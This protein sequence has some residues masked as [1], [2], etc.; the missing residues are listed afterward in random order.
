MV[1]ETNMVNM[2]YGDG[3]HHKTWAILI[4]NYVLTVLVV[5]LRYVIMSFMHTVEVEGTIPHKF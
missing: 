5:L 1:I 3:D 2:F 4:H